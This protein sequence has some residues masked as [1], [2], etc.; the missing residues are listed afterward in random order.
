LIL[1]VAAKIKEIFREGKDYPWPRPEVCPRCE[2]SGVWGHGFV[3]AL[4]DGLNEG[5]WLRRYRCPECGCVVRLRPEGYFSRFQASVDS[6][7]LSLSY[8]LDRE[9]WPPCVSRSRQG[10]WMRALRRKVEAYLGKSWG[11][12][13]IGG[14]DHLVSLGRNPV[15]R[16]I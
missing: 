13:L 7:R 14:F 2:V 11:G 10:H 8:R 5:L 1:F 6:I 9:R 4:F 12:G 16:S 15:S 3:L